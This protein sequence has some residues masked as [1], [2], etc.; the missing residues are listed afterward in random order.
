LT[1]V[2]ESSSAPCLLHDMG[3]NERNGRG[4]W[5]WTELIVLLII[6]AAV[7]LA[8]LLLLDEFFSAHGP[9]FH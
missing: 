3:D 6:L 5:L 2:K 9:L 8:A 4:H 7:V 1:Y